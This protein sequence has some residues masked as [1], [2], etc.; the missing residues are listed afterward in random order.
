MA[1]HPYLPENVRRCVRRQLWLQ[2]LVWRVE[3]ALLGMLW[4]ALGRLSP[5]RASRLGRA[6]GRRLGPRLHKT[7]HV[8][9]NLR[10][11]LPHLRG[12]ERE[13]LVPE[14]WGS[15]GA[16]LAEM[17]HLERIARE[18][19]SRL[20]LH[21]KGELRALREPGRPVVLVTAHTSNQQVATMAAAR[22]GLP[23]TAVYTPESNPYVERRVARFRRALRCRLLERKGSARAL[24]REL[25]RGGAIGI[26]GDHRFD[27][28]EPMPFFGA[29]TFVS[30]APA[31][32]ALRHGCELLPVRVERK[33]GARFRV[34]V[35]EPLHPG[36]PQAPLRERAHRMTRALVAH[37]ERW[38]REDP[39]EWL[40]TSRR[41]PKDMPPEPR[42]VCA[43]HGAPEA[44]GGRK[45]AGPGGVAS[46][47]GG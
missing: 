27:S 36:D 41:W 17:P 33:E 18:A 30:T 21:I 19:P 12:E 34:T 42:D 43:S 6:L 47:R 46:R 39:A 4:G 7:A 10:M 3:A 11:A 5:D 23:L 31:R 22:L 38:F 25:S 14:V 28:G 32:L 8:R 9:Q 40:C 37:F 29:P 13:A 2:H 15:W 35:F 1:K 20:E 24:V 44:P 16:M 26:V 45:A